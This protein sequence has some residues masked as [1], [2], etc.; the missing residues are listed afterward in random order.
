ML[1]R[2]RST[3]KKWVTATNAIGIKSRSG[4]YGGGTY[5]HKDIAF[6]FGSWLS[7]EFKL[8]LIKEFQR[9]K[10]NENKQ[11]SVDWDLKRTLSKMNYRVH[12]SAVKRHLIPHSI[13]PEDAKI[14]YASEA[15]VLNMALFGQTA[16]QWR[17]ANPDK[18]G[19][20]R[21]YASVEQLLVLANMENL[22]AEYIKMQI[23][24]AERLLKLN[25]YAIN[26]LRILEYTGAANKLIAN[27]PHKKTAIFR[28]SRRNYG[29]KSAVTKFNHF[30]LNIL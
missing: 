23:T 11:Q 30:A 10:E 2:S 24:Q 26:N 25:E 16:K 5:A 12:T 7:P 1:F 14:V 13:S 4:K 21:D 8:Y 15:D 9:L 20:M 27:N 17:E 28:R 19:N 18:D 3:P 6:E 22:N 29:W